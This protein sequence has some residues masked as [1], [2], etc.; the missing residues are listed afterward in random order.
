VSICK[1]SEMD[2]GTSADASCKSL[3]GCA[4]K[5]QFSINSTFT[6]L[7]RCISIPAP[8]RPSVQV[9]AQNFL[10][11]E[12]LTLKLYIIYIWFLK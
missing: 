6:L 9:R 12:G 2:Q 4:L 1:Y 10:I 5:E 11:G 8:F 7:S 3:V